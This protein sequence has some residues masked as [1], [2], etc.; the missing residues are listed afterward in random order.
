MNN[1]KKSSQLLSNTYI[2]FLITIV[3]GLIIWL[4]PP[5]T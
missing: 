3:I 5:P 2:K 1:T 4:I